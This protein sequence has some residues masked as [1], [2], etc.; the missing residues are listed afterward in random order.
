M[1]VKILEQ[2]FGVDEDEE[3]PMVDQPGGFTF[4]QQAAAPQVI[5]VL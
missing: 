3:E 5:V 2:Y 4:N 1:A